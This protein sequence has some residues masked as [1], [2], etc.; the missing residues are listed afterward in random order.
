MTGHLVFIRCDAFDSSGGMT[1]V[2]DLTANRA[3]RVREA[4]LSYEQEPSWFLG[5]MVP[6]MPVDT[7]CAMVVLPGEQDV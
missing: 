1:G 5:E 6:D 4:P 3:S 2:Y 7:E